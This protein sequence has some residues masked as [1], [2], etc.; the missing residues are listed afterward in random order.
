MLLEKDTTISV[1]EVLLNSISLFFGLE[2]ES[3]VF[4]SITFGQMTLQIVDIF[5]YPL[6]AMVLSSP[7][8]IHELLH[9]V[10]E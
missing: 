8:H 6:L 3:N 2:A 1:S 7:C 9:P 5:L 10:M 4:T